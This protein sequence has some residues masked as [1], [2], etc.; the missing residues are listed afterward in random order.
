MP[1]DITRALAV[2]T[3][4]GST[5]HIFLMSLAASYLFGLEYFSCTDDIIVYYCNILC[6]LNELLTLL[7]LYASEST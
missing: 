7:M 6:K 2:S 3:Y 1:E 5:I 4:G